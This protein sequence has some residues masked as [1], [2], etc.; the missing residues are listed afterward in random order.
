MNQANLQAFSSQQGVHNLQL[1]QNAA[2]QR[3]IG[4]TTW[5]EQDAGYQD[6][7]G[8]AMRFTTIS[9]QHKK[10]YYTIVLLIPNIYYDEA[11]QKYI[12]P[13]FDSLQFLA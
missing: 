12:Q 4:G 8:N 10:L 5:T 13:M 2:S 7:N 3:T 9:V 6:N 11:M 1:L